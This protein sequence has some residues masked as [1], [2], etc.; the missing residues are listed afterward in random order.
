MTASTVGMRRT[1]PKLVAIVAARC[2]SRRL[3]GK[4]LRPVLG[5]PMLAH[6]LERLRSVGRLDAIMIA[7]S[8]ERSDDAISAFAEACGVPCWRGALD[9][10]LGRFRDAAAACQADAVARISGDSPLIDP[11][12]VTAAAQL[13]LEGSA[14]IIS[15]VFP[16]SFPKGQSVEVLSRGALERLAAEATEAEDREHVT[17]QAYRHPD[18]F[19]IRN[20][21]AARPRPELQLSVDTAADFERVA[22]LMAATGSD[23]GLAGVER[24]VELADAFALS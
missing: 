13:Y 2:S 21:S 12:I 1:E 19:V 9:D 8:V 4:V 18:R 3:P 23:A 5:R 10:V 11:A 15:N 24:L 17:R 22:A 20:F 16:R 6:T 7:T 14:D